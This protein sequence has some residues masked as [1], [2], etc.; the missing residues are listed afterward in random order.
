MASVARSDSIGQGGGSNTSPEVRSLFSTPIVV[1]DVPDAASLNGELR[2]VIVERAETHPTTHHSNVGGWQSSWDMEKWG[3]AGAI[4]LLAIGR[5]LANRFTLDRDGHAGRGP[6]PDFFA[7]TWLGNMWANINRSGHANQIHS[8]PGA[9]WSGVYYV[10]DGGIAADPA[11]GGFLEFL[12]PRG[13]LPL[14]NAP[15]LRMA[16]GLTAGA[17]ERIQPKAGRLVLFPAWLMHQ[18][19]HYHGNAERISIAFNLAV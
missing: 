4:K 5:N 7:V 13:P 8:H 6:H 9:Y 18:V 15:H 14:M 11:L 16:G 3:G 1:H 19:S 17:V 12:D 2:R 10:D